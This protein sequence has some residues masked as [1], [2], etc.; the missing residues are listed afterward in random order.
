MSNITQRS[1]AHGEVS[2]SNYAGA[3]RAFYR[4]A[5]RTLLNGYVMKSGG[6]QP[7]PG[8]SYK[9][10]T[11]SSGAA[12]LVECVFDD[13]QN[14]VLEFGA[15][16]VR[17][18]KDGAL[19][20]G[21][22]IGS[23][24]NVTAY[25]AGI[26]LLHSGTYYACLQAHTSDTAND[27]PNDGTNRLDYWHALTA[28]T[29]ELPTDYGSSILKELQFVTTLGVLRISHNTVPLQKLV[30]VAN[31]QWYFAAIASAPTLDY[32]TNL[33]TD[34]VAGS[35]VSWTV[36]AY[37][38][39][40][41]IESLAAAP[42]S[43]DT[44][45]A[46]ASIFTQDWDA[47][48]GAT[49]YRIYKSLNGSVYGLVYEM[50]TSGPWADNGSRVIDLTTNP[51]EQLAD[52]SSAGTYPGVIGAYQQRIF[53]SGSVNEP[54]F[55]RGSKSGAPDDFTV[56][57]PLVDSDAVS[58]RMVN[59]RMVRP[60]HFVE[61]ARSLLLFANIGEVA[62]EGDDSGILTPSG[63]NPRF[64]SQNGAAK[65]PAPL[66]VNGTA[67]Y[68]QA[69]GGVVRDVLADAAGSDL[70]VLSSHLV[71]GYT[72]VD[73]CYQQTPHSIVWAVRSD[74]VLLS[75]TYQ[76]ESGVLGWARHTT[77]GTVESCACVPEATEDAVYL[78]V[79]RTINGST[80]RYVERFANRSAAIASLVC[81]DASST[82]TGPHPHHSLSLDLSG[83]LYSVPSD[84]T[85]GVVA[86]GSG[87]SGSFTSADVG[88]T[89]RFTR[90]GT[91]YVATI[92]GYTSA[93]V[94]TVS[95]VGSA[96]GWAD[97]TVLTT[98]DWFWT[99]V[100]GL[101]HLALEPVSVVLDGVCY[102]SPY[103]SAYTART[104]T[105]GGLLLLENTTAFATA[106]VGLPFVMDVQTLDID[107]SG[108]TVKDGRFLVTKVG[109]YIEQG[110]SFFAGTEEPTT[111][112]GFT[113]PGGG[114]MQPV[115]VMD[116]NENA[117]TTPQTGYFSAN[118]DGR[119]DDN[120]RIFLRHVDPTP[121][122][123]LA[124]SPQGHFP[125]GG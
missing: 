51:P 26:V 36:T 116:R 79:N 27:R 17:F 22:S 78:I 98:G 37:D 71:E 9:G 110:M 3:D 125:K 97:P 20:Q 63:I 33:T 80:V 93:T 75:L 44:E 23:W 5:L 11:K 100:S 46:L 43:G 31:A 54:D 15:N 84:T 92:S 105:A 120:G 61:V 60:R 69:R 107:Q 45:P 95:F 101:S 2:P 55:V 66:A 114:A 74:G 99:S 112:T 48:T 53:H 40:N 96:S 57:A 7:R 18:W 118:V 50:T 8:T 62:V 108:G 94:V 117:V 10:T 81:S 72:I 38:S 19:V 49:S 67:L 65:Y 106:I 1:F 90:A 30:R 32:P 82:A 24:A 122:T 41:D 109:A 111:A 119:F 124:L 52:F 86:T 77:D 16:Y 12:Q 35:V 34:A 39:V 73:W 91:S 64:I 47:V 85:G 115:T 113:L 13:D 123:L 102:A 59:A 29:Y 87:G 14:Y 76:R 103:N 25:A 58:F 28:L 83:A 68:V 70:T 89:F 88:R 21:V 121:L 42:V 104:V 56:S 6:I 4:Q